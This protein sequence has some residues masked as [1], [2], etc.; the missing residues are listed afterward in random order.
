MEEKLALVG[1]AAAAGSHIEINV[2]LKPFKVFT[3]VN[4]IH[5]VAAGIIYSPLLKG[6]HA[7]PELYSSI[8]LQKV[9]H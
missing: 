7:A 9:T 3:G 8:K 6:T 4:N 2:T 1:C 5:S